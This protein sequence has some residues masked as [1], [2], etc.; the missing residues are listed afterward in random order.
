ME[1]RDIPLLER[2]LDFF[3]LGER[4]GRLGRPILDLELL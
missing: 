2:R 3:A 4:L 1:E